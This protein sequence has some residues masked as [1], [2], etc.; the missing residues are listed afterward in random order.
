M[1]NAVVYSGPLIAPFYRDA[2]GKRL[3]KLLATILVRSARER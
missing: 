1:Q 2:R 3:K